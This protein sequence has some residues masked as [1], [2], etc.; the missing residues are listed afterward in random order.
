MRGEY[1][2]GELP[3]MNYC[4]KGGEKNEDS[5]GCISEIPPP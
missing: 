5:V 2:G 4:N 3:Y 1:L